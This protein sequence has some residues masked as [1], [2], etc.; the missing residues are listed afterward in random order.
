MGTA[1]PEDAHAAL[2]AIVGKIDLEL[3]QL[4][5]ATA[6]HTGGLRAYWAEL[7]GHLALGDPPELRACPCCR[8]AGI[9]TATRC[10]FCWTKLESLPQDGK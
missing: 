3:K 6:A 10:G 7:V 8:R 1:P 4:P 2:R 9:R 5:E